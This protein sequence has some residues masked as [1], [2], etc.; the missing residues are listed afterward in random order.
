M[1][2]DREKL[3]RMADLAQMMLDTKLSELRVARAGI[4]AEDAAISTLRAD[5]VRRAEEAAQA[6]EFDAARRAGMDQ[7]W[8]AWGDRRVIQ[9][10][11]RI[12]AF[13]AEQEIVLEEARRAFGRADV[14]KRLRDAKD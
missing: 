3:A 12:A 10:N 7:R 9:A 2:P 6:I 4:A 13:R 11:M 5:Q 8:L 14:L 1:R